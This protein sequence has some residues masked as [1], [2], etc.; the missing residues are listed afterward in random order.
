MPQCENCDSFVSRRYVRVF[1]PGDAR[2]PR[3]CPNCETK[4]RVGADTRE[5]RQ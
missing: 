5:K 1:A 2:N 4:V 3:V